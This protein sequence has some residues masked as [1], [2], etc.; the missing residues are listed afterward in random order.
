MSLGTEVGD[1]HIARLVVEHITGIDAVQGYLVARNAE[2]NQ[3]GRRAT[4]HLDSDLG[5]LLAP[6]TLHDVGALH[7]HTSNEGVVDQHDAVAS[8]DA[9]ALAGSTRDGLDDIERIL[10]HV[11]LN[12]NATELALQRFLHILGFLSIGVTAVRIQFL[13]HAHDG[14]LHQFVLVNRVDIE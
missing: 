8:Q 7:L 6:Q 2:G 11:K 12:A 5:A 1:A 14:I 4:A 3:V 10:L 9:H 13:Q